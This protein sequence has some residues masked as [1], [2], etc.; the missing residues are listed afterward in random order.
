VAAELTLL[1]AN[2]PRLASLRRLI[3][4]RRARLDAG[5]F[6]VEGPVPVAELLAAGAVL[7]EVYVDVEAWNNVDD[8]SPLRV[9]VR[10]AE[11]AGVPVWGLAASVFV[12][13]SDTKAPQGALAIALRTT[14]SI[15]SLPLDG[16]P[17]LVL[18]DISDPGNAG[19]LV[20]TAEAAGCRG[21]VFTGSSTDP[22]GPKAV[23]AAAGS[24]VRLPIVEAESTFDALEKLAEA[25][26][27][28]VA[29]VVCGGVA[30]ELLRLADPVAI[31]IGSE[32][33]G[34]SAEIIDRC[35]QRVTIPMVP[36]VESINAATAG[37][38]LLF[39]A[40]RQRRHV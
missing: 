10:E 13:V 33:H 4:R 11:A 38:V 31:V 25:G 2:N 7:E 34:L 37:A 18:A 6:V 15:D 32:A 21:V 8:R 20:R 26:R 36:S 16:G 22:F 12:S 39:E 40:A 3:G 28:L 29:T 1:S 24:I 27:S 14:V 23:R 19:T 17:V 30:P 5:R 9:L 35:N